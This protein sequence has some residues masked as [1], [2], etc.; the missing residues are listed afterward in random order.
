MLE[1]LEDRRLERGFFTLA[2]CTAAGFDSVALDGGQHTRRLFA[3]HHIDPRIRP[4]PQKTWR[5]GTT[6][7]PVV[8]GTEAAS[9]DHGE[10]RDLSARHSGHH[11]GAVACDAFVFVFAAD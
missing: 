11:L 8:A 1:L 2:P 7:H 6:A 4:H 3:T 9:D 5:V 10:F